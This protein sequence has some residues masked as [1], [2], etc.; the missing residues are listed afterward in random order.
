MNV[1]PRDELSDK[2]AFD[3]AGVC[4]GVQKNQRPLVVSNTQIIKS[5]SSRA[6]AINAALTDTELF[7]AGMFFQYW[8]RLAV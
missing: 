4:D 7:E 3:G 1:Q 6:G 2:G 8:P 5:R